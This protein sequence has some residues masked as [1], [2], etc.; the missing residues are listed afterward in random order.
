MQRA[1][2]IAVWI[3]QVSQIKL[4]CRA[5]AC[6]MGFEVA[7]AKLLGAAGELV[8]GT[9]R[10]AWGR[11]GGVAVVTTTLFPAAA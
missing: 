10:A 3:A 7:G 11:A 2:L 1:N 6:G 8:T 4:A 5:F 9:G